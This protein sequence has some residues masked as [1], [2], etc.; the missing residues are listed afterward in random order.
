M[1]WKHLISLVL[2]ALAR[3]GDKDVIEGLQPHSNANKLSIEG[4]QGLGFP[5]LDFSILPNLVKISLI[6]HIEHLPLLERLPLLK[7][8]RI[9]ALNSVKAIDCIGVVAGFPS[10]EE[11]KLDGMPNLEEWSPLK[12]NGAEEL[13]CLGSL[14]IRNCPRLIRFPSLSPL[15]HPVLWGC[16]IEM[17][18]RSMRNRSYLEPLDIGHFKDL[19]N[20]PDGLLQ[21]LIS[22]RRLNIMSCNQLKTLPMEVAQNS[23]TSLSIQDCS[24]LLNLSDIKLLSRI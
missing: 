5:W 11:L 4:Y 21:S 16:N 9:C 23:L 22:L 17:V 13:P 24:N 8:L 15:V 18:L 1:E 10:L 6:E 19:V 3:R 12:D 20:F 2:L 7:T 14:I